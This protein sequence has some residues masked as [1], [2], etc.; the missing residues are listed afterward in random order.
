[1]KS[2]DTVGTEVQPSVLEI[3][4]F[5]LEREWTRQPKLYFLWAR[6]TAEARLAM[7]EAKADAELAR[8]EA[9]SAVRDDPVGHGINGKVTEKMVE[10]A[11]LQ[12]A[13]HVGAVRKLARAK[14]RYEIMSALVSAL[15]QRKSALENLVRLYLAN[16]YAEPRAREH[17]EEL[18]EI[19][20]DRAFRPARRKEDG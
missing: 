17:E 9:D 18:E 10:A 7:D 14:H 3:D 5:N 11:V 19:Q 8:A 13:G 4:E 1:M 16:Y 6:E 15:E 12:S 2:N 20:K